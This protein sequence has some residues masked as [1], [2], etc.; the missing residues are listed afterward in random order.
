MFNKTLIAVGLV[1]LLSA[2]KPAAAPAPPAAPAEPAQPAAPVAE[3]ATPIT[4]QCGDE[5]I[6]A[7]FDNSA[8]NVSLSIG[9]V[10][11]VL[12]QAVSASGAR[13]AD[14]QGNE[15]WNKGS[16]ATLTRTGKPA[17]ECAQ[18]E[19]ASPWDQAKARGAS[20][21]AVGNEPG[22][23]VEVG[24]GEAPALSATLDNGS[25]NVEVAQAQALTGEHTGFA[26]K[27]ADGTAVELLIKREACTDA[28]SGEAFAASA[29]L[30]VGDDTYSGCGRFLA[31]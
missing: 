31:E 24:T 14:D 17:V 9:G 23:A 25:R 11:L 26:G 27:A 4:F 5:R 3:V 6:T 19:L 7:H 29:Q 22:W 15:F 30:K 13:Y 16:N 18:T 28:M 10:A 12:P 2:C 21:R 8:G 1:A 20:F